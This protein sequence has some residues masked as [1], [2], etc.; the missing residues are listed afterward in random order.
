MFSHDD[1]EDMQF[2]NAGKSNFPM[3][4]CFGGPVDGSELPVPVP[5]IGV[6][7][8]GY[9]H[10]TQDMMHYRLEEQIDEETGEAKLIYRFMTASSEPELSFP[11]FMRKCADFDEQ[12]NGPFDDDV[13]TFIF[14]EREE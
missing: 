8:S 7:I 13:E 2:E 11:E 3:V 5:E 9:C 12:H 14:E 1:Y 6:I 4:E 10:E